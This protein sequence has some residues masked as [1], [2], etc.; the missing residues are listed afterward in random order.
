MKTYVR[1]VVIAAI[2]GMG[3]FLFY[4]SAS[5][6][7]NL[8]FTKDKVMFYL[9][10]PISIHDARETEQNI[11]EER[12]KSSQQ[13]S[14]EEEMP[15]FCIWGQKEQA[16]IT[17]E[18]LSR[19]IQTDVIM[20]CG[21][22]EL[23]FADCRVLSTEDSR[24][25]LVDEWTAWCLFGSIEVVGQ[26]ISYE[27]NSYVIRKVLPGTEPIF[28]FQVVSLLEQGSAKGNQTEQLREDG[29]LNRVTMQNPEGKFREDLELEWEIR[30]L[31]VVTLDLELLRGIGGFC[32]LLIPATLCICFLWKLYCEYREQKRLVWK[33]STAAVGLVVTF[34]FF[35]LLKNQV[36]IPDDYI[37]TRWSEFSFWSGLWYQKQAALKLMLQIPK[38]N[39][40]YEWM[41]AFG[42]TIGCGILAEVFAMICAALYCK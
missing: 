15:E 42:R 1:Y 25:C 28:A 9:K 20:L 6:W 11:Q 24:G 34:C 19:S 33:V 27:G 2:A 39:L 30:G 7:G 17:N 14:A 38:T 23:L 5:A 21:N 41:N 8:I 29:V 10:Q 36:N 26:E 40:D 18:N 37:P 4:L 12:Q 16:V 22:P 32:V 35:L 31:S 13:E 3:I